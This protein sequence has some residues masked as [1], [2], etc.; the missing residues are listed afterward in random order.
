M[1]NFKHTKII[2]FTI[3][4]ENTISVSTIHIISA[5][6]TLLTS[7]IADQ[8]YTVSQRNILEISLEITV[9]QPH[10]DFDSQRTLESLQKQ[11]SQKS[12]LPF[13]KGQTSMRA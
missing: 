2:T 5:N 8:C 12:I 10:F 13:P 7:Q 11:H 1:Q 9:I 4:K 6:H 3:I